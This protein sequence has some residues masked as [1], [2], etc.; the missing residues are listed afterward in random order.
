[1][2][3]FI[4]AYKKAHICFF[5]QRGNDVRFKHFIPRLQQLASSRKRTHS[6]LVDPFGKASAEIPFI[7]SL[8]FTIPTL[9]PESACKRIRYSLPTTAWTIHLTRN[10]DAA[11]W[12]EDYKGTGWLSR[13][14]RE[15]WLSPVCKSSVWQYVEF[16]AVNNPVLSPGKQWVKS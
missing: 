7:T 11:P 14:K 15:A 9:S 10:K 8:D 6:A 1:M 5:W 12:L 2:L 16:L 4:C 3:R 13:Q